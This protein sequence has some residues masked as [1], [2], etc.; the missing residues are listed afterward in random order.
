M[1]ANIIIILYSDIKRE[2]TKLFHTPSMRLL[3]YVCVVT[4]KGSRDFHI[5]ML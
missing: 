5:F 3:T 1:T 4:A 2:S